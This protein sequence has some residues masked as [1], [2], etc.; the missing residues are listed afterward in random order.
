M[1]MTR[2][3]AAAI[4]TAGISL[5][6]KADVHVRVNQSVTT[7]VS[8]P[9]R[10]NT[11]LP[12]NAQPLFTSYHNRTRRQKQQTSAPPMST[13]PPGIEDDM[14][15]TCKML[16][17][18]CQSPKDDESGDACRL[19]FPDCYGATI[20]RGKARASGIPDCDTIRIAKQLDAYPTTRQC[21]Q[22]S[23]LSVFAILYE[24]P[25]V[26][27][28]VHAFNRSVACVDFFVNMNVVMR[29]HVPCNVDTILY[30]GDAFPAT[31]G[32]ANATELSRTFQSAV[33]ELMAQVHIGYKSPS[34]MSAN[35]AAF[36]QFRNTTMLHIA[37]DPQLSVSWVI[38][39]LIGCAMICMGIELCLQ[40]V[41]KH[42][43]T[44]PK[45]VQ[46][47]HISCRDLMTGGLLLFVLLQLE[48]WQLVAPGD[49][50][51]H[52]FKLAGDIVVYFLWSGILQAILL[53][54]RLDR[55]IQEVHAMA[56]RS[57]KE[58]LHVA[59]SAGTVTADEHVPHVFRRGV[60]FHIVRRFFLQLH[61]LPR[62]FLY[63]HYLQLVQDNLVLEMLRLD[64]TTFICLV[65]TYACY[66]SVSHAVF[67][68]IEFPD[69][70]PEMS[71]EVMLRAANVYRPLALQYRLGV[72]TVLVVLS[73]L[74]SI[75]L[76]LY[77]NSWQHK[78][79]DH[80]S[81][82]VNSMHVKTLLTTLQAISV[83]ETD[84][85]TEP[86]ADAV[87]RMQG[88]ADAL[89]DR[90]NDSAWSLLVN[91]WRARRQSTS[92]PNPSPAFVLSART[93][94]PALSRGVLRGLAKFGL[95][96]NA[97]YFAL[98]FSAAVVIVV[99]GTPWWYRAYV[100]GLLA[101]LVLHVTVMSANVVEKLAFVTATVFAS[102]P[103]MKQALT[104]FAN[105]LRSEHSLSSITTT[106][107]AATAS[108]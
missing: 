94:R 61:R 81:D 108:T 42:C 9:S 91:W 24:Q 33:N 22:S 68:A 84:E 26:R 14:S 16:P 93:V 21:M 92:A 58:F 12:S 35:A 79:V 31:L 41:E 96:L 105:Q 63:S 83:K 59:T 106:G 69:E 10:T 3:L 51:D 54:Y 102:E 23:R 86:A 49:L 4:A 78:I 56:T 28:Q 95:A 44:Q 67:L 99:P 98:L 85:S 36:V 38:T 104:Q 40:L 52:C 50:Y 46:M 101:L 73:W 18:I 107:T 80:A 11:P 65:C 70:S 8:A 30:D 7:T 6:H 29:H 87:Q 89:A 88:L 74:L 37:L 76:Y 15:Y 2:L 25:L 62:R 47:F 39:F 82:C 34:N 66:F 1:N 17:K 20:H 5:A 64:V 97:L 48:T 13:G 71:R 75:V 100:W 90:E 72:L 45:F 57:S 60:K 27:G 55:R 32:E 77:M 43:L 19:L 103:E 53:F